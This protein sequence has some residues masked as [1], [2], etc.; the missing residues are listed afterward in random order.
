MINKLR[1]LG[2]NFQYNTILFLVCFSFVKLVLFYSAHSCHCSRVFNVAFAF[3]IVFNLF[4]LLNEK[5]SVTD[6][7]LWIFPAEIRVVY[8]S[9]LKNLGEKWL[10]LRIKK[11]CRI[12][13]ILL[14]GI[15]YWSY[16]F[17]IIYIESKYFIG[18]LYFP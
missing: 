15:F 8:D 7:E 14:F 9:N 11:L 4:C 17:C 3:T 18:P 6:F 10:C 13:F 16:C 12:H 1:T 2:L 5:S